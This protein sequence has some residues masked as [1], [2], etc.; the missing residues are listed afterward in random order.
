MSTA[1]VAASHLAASS[2][3]SSLNII[4]A[5]VWAAYGRIAN[6][7]LYLEIRGDVPPAEFVM[8]YYRQ[9]QESA[10]A[11]WLK[12]TGLRRNRGDSDP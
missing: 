4:Q 5:L 9:Q 8:A 7:D 6:S 3:D 12:Q 2:H 10:M 11:A 1:A